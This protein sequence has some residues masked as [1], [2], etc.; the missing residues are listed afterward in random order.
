[1]PE[2]RIM[3]SADE[4][5]VLGSNGTT[6][7]ASTNPSPVGVMESDEPAKHPLQN[8]WTLWYYKNDRSNSWEDN[9]KEV[10]LA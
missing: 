9:L 3:G 5:E 7:R 1:M 6:S 8:N 4:E 2:L 10:S